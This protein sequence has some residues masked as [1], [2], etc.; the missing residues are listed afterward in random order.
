MTW[1]YI[2]ADGDHREDRTKDFLGHDRG[3]ECYVLNDGRFDKSLLSI[4][5]ASVDNVAVFDIAADS[6]E[7]LIVHHAYIMLVCLDVFSMEF[8]DCLCEFFYKCVLDSLMDEDIVRG[9]ACLSAIESFSPRKSFS[10]ALDVCIFV[11]DT[12]ALSA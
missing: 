5:S 1:G 2:R 7:C 10:R 12:R 6:F 3:V 11:D 9:D 8:L 4:C